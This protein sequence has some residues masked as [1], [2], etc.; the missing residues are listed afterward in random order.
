MASQQPAFAVHHQQS[1]AHSNDQQS[2]ADR[3]QNAA[4]HRESS[5]KL[6]VGSEEWHRQRRENHKQVER[7]RRETINDG[8][9]EIAKMVPGSEKNKGSILQRAAQYIQQL[10]DN[11]AATIEKW[12]LE[13][14]L[15]DQAINELSQQVE[16]LKNEVERLRQ[17]NERMKRQLGEDND[18]HTKKKA[19]TDHS[20]KDEH[21]SQ[22]D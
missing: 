15:T 19:K 9:N 13:K 17:D 14:L 20:D 4:S 7:R 2:A 5:N 12:T 18:E 11:E 6:I 8:I 3:Q 1:N 10:K 21:K 22:K 16:V